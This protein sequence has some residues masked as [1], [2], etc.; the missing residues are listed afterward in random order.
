VR[1]DDIPIDRLEP[2]SEHTLRVFEAEDYLAALPAERGLLD[3]RFE[4]VE[5]HR[6]E[7]ELQCRD[8]RFE[9]LSQTLVL[10]E[11]LA[12]R[13]GLDRS[14]AVLLP[15]FGRGRR[16]A[17]VLASAAADLELKDDERER[18][19]TAALAVVRRLLELGFLVRTEAP[20]A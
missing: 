5:G 11:G 19:A 18:F 6:L 14:T 9:V 3:E 1:L 2:A 20:T 7:Q 4:L 15:H 16:L 17:D 12:F 8:D 13:A 10:T